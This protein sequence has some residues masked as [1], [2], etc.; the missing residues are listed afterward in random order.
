M[1]SRKLLTMTLLLGIQFGCVQS[2]PIE[3]A[4]DSNAANIQNVTRSLE[5]HEVQVLFSEVV[6]GPGGEIS[7]QSSEFQL[8]ERNYFYPASTVKFPVALLALEKLAEDPRLNRKTEF[9][10]GEES[11]ST[12]FAKEIT[13]LFVVSDNQA[14]NR[15]FEYLGKDEINRRLAE[16]GIEA[17]LS[18]RLS[19]PNSDVLNY[20]PVRFST[21][22][23]VVVSQASQSLP[24]SRPDINR[25]QKG[26]AYQQDGKLVPEPFDFSEKNYLPIHS[27]HQ[28]MQRLI[29][30]ELFSAS[31]RFHLSE[32]DRE[33]VL[34][35][36]KTLPREAGFSDDEYY[37]SYVKFFLF[38]DN[39]EPIPSHIEIYNKV[40]Y[41]YGTLTDC[42]YIVDR[43][44]GK[45]YIITATILVNDNQT[46][47]DDNYEY[48]SIGIP[49][50]AELGRQL[51]NIP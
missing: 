21:P 14:Y 24:I 11:E 3:R 19:V 7:F 50:L 30:P 44:S 37:D 33:F 38:G 9:T 22:A 39:K 20:K 51:T 27:L 18:H 35:S 15:L 34:K 28:I 6:R 48:E 29:F 23:G 42:A 41:A 13:E 17:R 10:L 16:K 32:D 1:S 12:S 43:S 46:F 36:M 5:T 2:T 31:E 40:G 26:R 4:L 49:F 45:E 25:L 47:N 8:D